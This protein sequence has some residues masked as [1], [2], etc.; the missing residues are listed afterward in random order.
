MLAQVTARNGGNLFGTERR[1][2]NNSTRK[3]ESSGSKHRSLDLS[4]ITLGANYR[5]LMRGIATR[6]GFY[7]VAA[8]MMSWSKS[9]QV[10]IKRFAGHRCHE[11]LFR[12]RIAV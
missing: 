11:S 1:S 5:S 8:S 6:Q 12:T 10:C 4:V 7:S 2:I 3:T 9:N